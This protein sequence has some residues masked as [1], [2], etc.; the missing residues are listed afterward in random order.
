MLESEEICNFQAGGF[1]CPENR[2]TI[3]IP[4]HIWYGELQFIPDVPIDT[5]RAIIL[6]EG[7]GVVWVGDGKLLA[8]VL[9]C[10]EALYSRGEFEVRRIFVQGRFCQIICA[11]SPI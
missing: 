9:T 7:R 2:I 1:S 3:I 10:Y 11:R 6:E 8:I 4:I 5:G